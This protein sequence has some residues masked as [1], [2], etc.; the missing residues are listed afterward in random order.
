MDVETIDEALVEALRKLTPKQRTAVV[1]RYVNDLDTE[2]I[3]RH[4]NCSVATVRTHLSRG[5]Q[6]L[7]ESYEYSKPPST[8][9]ASTD[10]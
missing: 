5:L 9:G 3:A 7:R 4:L 1:L 2:T 10:E 6:T 8:A